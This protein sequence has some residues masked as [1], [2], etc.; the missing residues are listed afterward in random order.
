MAYNLVETYHQLMTKI[1]DVV[2]LRQ[3]SVLTFLPP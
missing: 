1:I 3:L 2:L